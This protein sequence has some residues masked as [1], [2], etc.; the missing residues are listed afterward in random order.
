[1]V[2]ELAPFVPSL[3]FYGL[4]QNVKPLLLHP[5][6]KWVSALYYCAS[7]LV[8]GRMLQSVVDDRQADRALLGLTLI[9]I[10][11]KMFGVAQ[12]LTPHFL[13]GLVGGYALHRL[14][15][16]VPRRP[17]DAVLLSTLAVLFIAHS[18][19][20]YELR[21]VPARFGWLPF[22]GSL[23]GGMLSNARSLGG[24]VF[25]I[26]A[27]LW[28][29]GEMRGRVL[30]FAFALTLVVAALE[31]AQTWVVGRT[32]DITTPFVAL[33]MGVVLNRAS[34]FGGGGSHALGETHSRGAQARY[35][36]DRRSG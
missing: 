18:L 14:V 35:T 20:P 9:A 13:L 11:I 30:G 25:A 27:M 32:G 34:H 12:A 4:K 5:E 19:A 6:I 22:S 28:L 29:V 31:Y 8:I 2:A 17:Y 10:G 36:Q 33:I 24:I 23:E 21:D 15:S 7:A 26:G 16:S 1:M 3:D